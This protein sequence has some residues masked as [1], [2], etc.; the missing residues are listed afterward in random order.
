MTVNETQPD[1]M[2]QPAAYPRVD[3]VFDSSGK[4][5]LLSPIWLSFFVPRRYRAQEDGSSHNVL[6]SHGPL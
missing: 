3:Q 1:Q 5:H 4:G 6:C 2:P